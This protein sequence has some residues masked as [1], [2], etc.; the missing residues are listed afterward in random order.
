MIPV[1]AIT[2]ILYSI[3]AIAGTSL[4]LYGHFKWA[5][6]LTLIVTQ[7]WR[8][9]SEFFRADYRGNAKFSAYQVMALTAVLYMGIIAVILPSDNASALSIPN[10]QQFSTMSVESGISMLPDILHGLKL[11]WQPSVLISLELFWLVTFLYTGRS[12]VTGSHISFYVVK[13]KI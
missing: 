1:Q 7:I 13:E 4:F 5:M 3:T 9:L 8:V 10:I 6:L 11:F 12:F 2:S